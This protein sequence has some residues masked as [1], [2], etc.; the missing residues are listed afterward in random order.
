MTR[1]QFRYRINSAL[2]VA[3]HDRELGA[4]MAILT[5]FLLEEPQPDEAFDARDV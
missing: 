2:E 4:L 5:L 3:P 1:L